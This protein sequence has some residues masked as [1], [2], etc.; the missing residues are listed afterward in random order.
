MKAQTL[1]PSRGK[2]GKNKRKP[3]DTGWFCTDRL[4]P[5]LEASRGKKW[6]FQPSRTWTIIH[7]KRRLRRRIEA[8]SGIYKARAKSSPGAVPKF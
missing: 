6:V 1:M 8:A 2:W 5:L 7:G 3:S 4:L